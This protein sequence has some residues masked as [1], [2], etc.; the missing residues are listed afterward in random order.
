MLHSVEWKA[1]IVESLDAENFSFEPYRAVFEALAEGRPDR[2]DDIPARAFES[3]QA[4]GLGAR[5]PDEMFEWVDNSFAADRKSR[6]IRLLDRNIALSTDQE[7]KARL[8]LQKQALTNERN[9]KRA[10]W[11]ILE[12]ARRKGAPGS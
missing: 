6:Q 8:T 5:S 10:T 1:R 7:E 3:M 2:L 9:A 4:E 11:K 12:H